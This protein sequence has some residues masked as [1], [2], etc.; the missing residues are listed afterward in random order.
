[1][2]IT[3]LQ[4]NYLRTAVSRMDGFHFS[5]IILEKC[6]WSRPYIEQFF[7]DCNPYDW[8]CARGVRDIE[9][10]SKEDYRDYCVRWLDHVKKDMCV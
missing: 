3:E 8:L 9:R 6:P 4:F 10:A 5:G 1:M 7:A 2:K